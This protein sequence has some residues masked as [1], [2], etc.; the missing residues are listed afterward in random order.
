MEVIANNQRNTFKY[1]RAALFIGLFL[2]LLLG[3]T[4]LGLIIFEKTEGAPPLTVPQTTIF[5]ANDG[6]RI[7]EVSNGEK[8]YWVNL[9]DIS[10]YVVN[11]TLAIEDRK[12]YNHFGFDIKRIVGAGLMDLKTMTKAQ[13]ASTIT[14]QYARN[15]FL[16]HNKT[17]SRKFQEA[18]YTIRL[19]AN[20]SKKEILEGYLN[21]IYYGHG[22]YG[23]EAAARY[24]F[25]K[26]A[27]NLTLAE[28]TMLVGIPKGPSYYSPLINKNKAGERQKVILQ[29]MKEATFI[30]NG[31]IQKALHEKLVYTS[32]STKVNGT[33]APYFQDAVQYA[34][35]HETGISKETIKSG[36]LHIYTTIDTKLQ[37]VAEKSVATTISKQSKLEA[38]LVSIDPTS[39]E[40]K[41]LIG[42][43]NYDKSSYNRATQAKR[44]PGSTFKPFLYYAALEHGFTPSTQVRSEPTTF[45]FDAGRATYTPRNFNNYYANDTITLA[46]A[47]ALSDNVFAVKTNLAIGEDTLVQTAKQFGVTSPL[48]PLPSL[49]LG[50]EP[51]RVIEM[52]NAYGMLANGGKYISPV[53]IKKVTNYQGDILYEQKQEN[54]QKLDE[55]TAFVTTELMTGMFDAKL[56][57]YT[58][59]TGTV[60]ANKLTREYAGKSGTTA[61]DSWMIGYTPQLVTGVWTGYDRNATLDRLDERQ[62]A[63]QIWSDVME[64]GLQN[65]P[66]QTF[67]PPEGVVGVH[68]DP[69]SGKMATEGCSGRLTYYLAGTEPTEYCPIHPN[70]E[71]QAPPKMEQKKNW[72]EKLW[73][74]F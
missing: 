46:Q 67:S 64:K 23:I 8:R 35:E 16:V 30:T 43:R 10:P 41:A 71:K 66:L 38:A 11:A 17:W 74:W 32:D 68:V 73:G 37:V 19:E 36:G 5:Y 60:I 59:V 61:T 13:G 34:L 24:Y 51:V 53:F 14:Q 52:V 27:K 18:L 50:T 6:T 40:V 20:Y 44:Q 48:H 2:L 31:D 28:A 49:A 1:I 29:E 26:P 72:F 62:Y 55:A 3:I 42:G 54:K 7:G 45:T 65:E 4:I 57:D 56:N 47:I 39:G 22:R 63:K 33:I 15:L 12:F 58:T 70:V 25:G 9:K 69:D 21:T